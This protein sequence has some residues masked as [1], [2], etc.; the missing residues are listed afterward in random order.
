MTRR[1]PTARSA[2]SRWAIAVVVAAMGHAAIVVATAPTASA[3]AFPS[4]AVTTQCMDSWIADTNAKLAT[5]KGNINYERG[6]RWFIHP[7]YGILQ[8][9]FVHSNGAPD[10]LRI[11][12]GANR[13]R[14][15]WDWWSPYDSPY[16]SASGLYTVYPFLDAGVADIRVF[17][18]G[19]IASLTPATVPATSPIPATSPVPG[20]SPVAG[21][22]GTPIGGP[23]VPAGIS[24]F[25]VIGGKR[26]VKEG[27]VIAVP[28]YLVNTP[29]LA[30]VNVEISYDSAIVRVEGT[31]A[32]GAFPPE[33]LFAANP[34]EAGLV[35]VGVSRKDGVTGTGP[36]V[37]VTFRAVGKPGQESPLTIRVT[38][39]DDAGGAALTA[40]LSAGVVKIVDESGRL[41][42]DCSGDNELAVNDAVCAL[43]MSVE[44]RPVDLLMDL[45]KDGKVTSRDATLILQ[46]ITI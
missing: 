11:N 43:E 2:G 29:N 38:K 44:L 33:S 9:K 34:G 4:S 6:K 7:Q 36:F 17:V 37:Q 32:K 25:F 13:D 46:R 10:D 26:V 41:P 18:S 42:G 12:Y 24:G 27:G 16:A 45:D 8:G 31:P 21:P 39:A 30:N 20:T 19:C 35:L 1:P 3:Q 40:T 5:F 23:D 28:F 22:T 15:M 14:F